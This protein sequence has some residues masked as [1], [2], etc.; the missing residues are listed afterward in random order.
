M[1]K[2]ILTSNDI[3]GIVENIY[4]SGLEQDVGLQKDIRFVDENGNEIEQN[5]SEYLNIEFYSWRNRL[6]EIK[7]NEYI[8]ADDWLQQLNINMDKSYGL[9]EITDNE[10]VESY[11]IDSAT[12]SGRITFL[13]QTSKINTLEYYTD[14]LANELRGYPQTIQNTNGERI[15][16]IVNIGKIIYTNEPNMNYFGEMVEC[17]CNFSI[18]YLA[19]A[20]AYMPDMISIAFD[21]NNYYNLAITKGSFNKIFINNSVTKYQRPEMTGAVNTAMS[22]VFTLSFYEFNDEFSKQLDEYFWSAGAF[23]IGQNMNNNSIKINKPIYLRIN[24]RRGTDYYYKM[25][26]DNMSKSI[27][28]GGF[29]VNTLTLKPYAKE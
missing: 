3:K 17:Y 25:V 8:G 27:T 12:I 21:E 16:A 5:I 14:S 2:I 22:N 23:K 24:S 11:D 15:Y 13:V 1:N 28:N 26:I 18:T 19:N 4:K 20:N 10:A 6:V 9:V 29:I 7:N